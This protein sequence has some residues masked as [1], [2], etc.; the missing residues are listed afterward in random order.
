MKIKELARIVAE[1]VKDTGETGD[2]IATDLSNLEIF[3]K[4]RETTFEANALSS[5][6]LPDSTR[7][8]RKLSLEIRSFPIQ[9]EMQS[10]LATSCPWSPELPFATEKSP[11]LA[12]IFY[13]DLDLLRNLDGPDGFTCPEF[14]DCYFHDSASRRRTAY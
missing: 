5:G 12:L 10:L 11:Y 8:K 13:L 1:K 9:K 14:G 2:L 4:R 6:L 7:K 3:A